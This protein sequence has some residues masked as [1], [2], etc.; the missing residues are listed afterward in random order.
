[1]VGFLKDLFPGLGLP[2]AV[3]AIVL[4]GLATAIGLTKVEIGAWATGAMVIV[5]CT[6]LGIVT[7]A[8]MANPHQ[9]LAEV[10]FHP[11]VPGTTA[12]CRLGSR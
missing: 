4:L 5:E 1:M 6:V 10:T 12:N 2:D 8:A 11:T 7:V 9:N 3:I